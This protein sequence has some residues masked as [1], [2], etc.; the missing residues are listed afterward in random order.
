VSPPGRAAHRPAAHRLSPLGRQL[1]AN[2][3]GQYRPPGRGTHRL[4]A[5]VS[6][7]AAGGA[8]RISRAHRRRQRQSPPSTLPNVTMSGAI[9]RV[10]RRAGCRAC[11]DPS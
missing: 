9:R 10:R 4:P 11:P 2:D 1:V 3:G 5:V 6:S 8:S 7:A